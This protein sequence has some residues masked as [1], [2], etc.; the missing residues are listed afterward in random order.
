M[1]KLQHRQIDKKT[2]YE[3]EALQDLKERLKL[4]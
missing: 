2:K 3:L 4:G 1:S